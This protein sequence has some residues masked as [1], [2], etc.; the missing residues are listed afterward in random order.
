HNDF[1]Q[2]QVSLPIVKYHLQYRY[3]NRDKS[4]PQSQHGC[5]KIRPCRTILLGDF[6]NP[7]KT[8]GDSHRNTP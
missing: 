5:D 7:N 6:P 3:Y 4:L 1:L 2:I 8:K